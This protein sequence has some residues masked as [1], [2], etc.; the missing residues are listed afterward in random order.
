MAQRSIFVTGDYILDHH[1]YEGRRHHYGDRGGYGVQV[2][3][4]LGGAA[5]EYGLLKAL[6]EQVLPRCS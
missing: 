3:L 1:I 5:L 4:E 6:R 2:K